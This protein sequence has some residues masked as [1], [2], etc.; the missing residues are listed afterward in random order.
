M[1]VCNTAQT[2]ELS[3]PLEHDKQANQQ[4]PNTAA[5]SDKRSLRLADIWCFNA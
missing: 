1:P 5:M 3:T 2:D 4:R